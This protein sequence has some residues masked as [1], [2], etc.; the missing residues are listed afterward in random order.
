VNGGLEAKLLQDRVGV[1]FP[2]PW[3]LGM[4]LHCGE[5]WDDMTVWDWRALFVVD[6]PF[7]KGSI[8]TDK[9]TLLWW[10]GFGEC[11]GDV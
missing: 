8:W 4:A 1:F 5:D 3:G 6:P 2:E 7:M 10:W 11:V 9:K